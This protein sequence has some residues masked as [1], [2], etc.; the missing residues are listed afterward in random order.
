M[1]PLLLPSSS[2]SS[3]KAEDLSIAISD[4]CKTSGTNFGWRSREGRGRGEMISKYCHGWRAVRRFAPARREVGGRGSNNTFMWRKRT[5]YGILFPCPRELEVCFPL[6]GKAT[7]DEPNK[8][9][10]KTLKFLPQCSVTRC[11]SKKK[12]QSW[13]HCRAATLYTQGQKIITSGRN[14]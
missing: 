10:P 6:R 13:S 9:L 12:R 14:H 3:P 8:I 2:P 4:S 1:L 11:C 7:N 5:Y